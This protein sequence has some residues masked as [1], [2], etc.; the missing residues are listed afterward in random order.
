MGKDLLPGG[1]FDELASSLLLL[2]TV[3]Q[4]LLAK[5]IPLPAVAN[6]M[7][8]SRSSCPKLAELD[9]SPPKLLLL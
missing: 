3:K 8:S 4:G 5:N 9:G 7:Q 2:W 1:M 6:I